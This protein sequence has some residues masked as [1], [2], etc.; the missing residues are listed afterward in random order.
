MGNILSLNREGY[1]TNNYTAYLGSRLTQILGFSNSS[2]SYDANG[3]MIIDSQKNIN[4]TY[5]YLNLPL[6]ISGSHMI[7]YTYDA[8]GNKLRKQSSTAGIT[9]YVKGI[10]YKAGGVIDFIQTRIWVT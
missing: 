2:Y 9:D 3:N 6:Q 7:T 4:L 8:N 1:G 10:Q 5:N